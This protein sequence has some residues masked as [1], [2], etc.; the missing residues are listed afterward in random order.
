MENVRVHSDHIA[1][2][3]LGQAALLG[4]Q[5]FQVAAELLELSTDEVRDSSR[6]VIETAAL[7]PND[8]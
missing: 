7:L 3:P 4:E 6:G 2:P 1:D 5:I 8:R